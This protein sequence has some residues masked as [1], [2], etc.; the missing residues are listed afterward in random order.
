MRSL[1]GLS[2]GLWFFCLTS[3]DLSFIGC[4]LVYSM[5]VA[6]QRWSPGRCG[7]RQH[8]KQCCCIQYVSG[9]VSSVMLSNHTIYESHFLCCKVI[10]GNAKIC[11]KRRQ[12]NSFTGIVLCSVLHSPVRNV[13]LFLHLIP[14]W[15]LHTAQVH[16]CGW[17]VFVHIQQGSFEVFCKI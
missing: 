4:L 1:W 5:W 17:S 6:W 2:C 3:E 13:L 10:I 11:P 7:G 16:H 12:Y 8:C 15:F 14:C 9:C